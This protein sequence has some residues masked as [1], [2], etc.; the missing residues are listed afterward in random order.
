M[1]NEK[2]EALE[3]DG[4]INIRTEN[5]LTMYNNKPNQQKFQPVSTSARRDLLEST[6]LSTRPK[7][8][9]PEFE[10]SSVTATAA[11]C[12]GCGGRLD[13][14]DTLQLKFS[15]CRK[16][17]SVYGRL[18]AAR[19]KNAKRETRELLERFVGGAK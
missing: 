2:A 3:S 8:E 10:L 4:L 12:A 5:Q 18:G 14:D 16:C 9:L 6:K 15:G 19:E 7:F 13:G 11:V 1:K 17:I